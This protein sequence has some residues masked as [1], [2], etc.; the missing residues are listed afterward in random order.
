MILLILESIF[1]ILEIF[2]TL[3]GLNDF[4]I[5]ARIFAIFYDFEQIFLIYM[6]LG[7]I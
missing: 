1:V 2:E 5:L 7:R 6:I 4:V 3:K